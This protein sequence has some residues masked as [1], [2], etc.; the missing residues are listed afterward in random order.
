MK[1]SNKNFTSF[2]K[3]LGIVEG[4]FDINVTQL[5]SFFT[6]QRNQESLEIRWGVI[7]DVLFQTFSI[8][9]KIQK[10]WQI[11]FFN[12]R[13]RNFSRLTAK[14]LLLD[15]IQFVIVQTADDLDQNGFIGAKSIHSAVQFTGVIQR[16]RFH[17]CNNQVFKITRQF[18]YEL[19]DEIL[20]WKIL[21]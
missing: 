5:A 17:H 19:F 4:C 20:Y 10:L 12:L 15:N 16:S 11:F 3:F 21:I 6:A 13:K 1:R 7:F 14:I 9:W 18:R 8:L 2:M